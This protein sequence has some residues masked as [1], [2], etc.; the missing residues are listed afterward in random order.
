MGSPSYC[1]HGVPITASGGWA[2]LRDAVRHAYAFCQHLPLDERE[3]LKTLYVEIDQ[4]LQ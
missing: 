3:L 4:V 1:P 2:I